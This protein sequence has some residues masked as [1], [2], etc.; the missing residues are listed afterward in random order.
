MDGSVPP[1]DLA[2]RLARAGVIT[3]LLHLDPTELASEAKDL[4]EQRLLSALCERVTGHVFRI[5][6][7]EYGFQLDPDA[8]AAFGGV[9]ALATLL[10][11]EVF[12]EMDPDAGASTGSTLSIAACPPIDP[13]EALD[14]VALMLVRRMA[15]A[16]VYAAGPAAHSVL[17]AQFAVGAAA[18]AADA[19]ATEVDRVADRVRALIPTPAM[20]AAEDADSAET[21]AWAQALD[22]K[23]SAALAAQNAQSSAAGDASANGAE[24]L[25]SVDPAELANLVA[26]DL[27]QS[28]EALTEKLEAVRCE[29]AAGDRATGADE[30]EAKAGHA[31]ITRQLA[32]LSATLVDQTALLSKIADL[33]TPREQLA[34]ELGQAA[35]A[36]LVHLVGDAAGA[37]GPGL[38]ATGAEHVAEGDQGPPPDTEY[39]DD[40][41]EAREVANAREAENA[42]EVE[43]AGEAEDAGGAHDIGTDP[44]EMQA[45]AEPASA[46]LARDETDEMGSSDAPALALSDEMPDDVPADQADLE[47]ATVH[48]AFE[49]EGDDAAL[50]HPEAEGLEDETGSL[51]VAGEGEAEGDVETVTAA[52]DTTV[53]SVSVE[54]PPDATVSVHCDKEILTEEM[55]EDAVEELESAVE[56]AIASHP[57]AAELDMS[58]TDTATDTG[59]DEMQQ[60][61]TIDAAGELETV[62]DEDGDQLGSEPSVGPSAPLA[63]AMAGDPEPEAAAP[64]PQPA[65][66]TELLDA[67]SAIRT[68]LDALV[69]LAAAGDT[70]FLDR[71]DSERSD[72]L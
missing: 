69:T 58:P 68:Q 51:E 34:T 54:G 71:P 28:F 10:G 35:L 3:H 33:V 8:A 31:A 29:F 39:V 41:G 2:D 46:E 9:E 43:D 26:Q 1:L 21:P 6:H 20:L 47:L 56:D 13:A 36:G 42:G 38:Q 4:L 5:G 23:L 53:V 14:D 59:L 72:R 57:D 64:S 63:P 40:A 60:D 12:G 49:P 65:F 30:L 70:A 55:A 61:E 45:S 11:E 17:D 22:D 7:F 27:A 32:S 19:I 37:I 67:L 16:A 15:E 66:R 18:L 24:S 44:E 52:T 25:A 62:Q 50:N 48:G